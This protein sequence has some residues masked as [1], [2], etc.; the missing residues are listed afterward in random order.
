MMWFTI[1]LAIGIIF[2][3]VGVAIGICVGLIVGAAMEQRAVK[4]D[5]IY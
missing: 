5:K 2:K 4:Q 1:C 3:A